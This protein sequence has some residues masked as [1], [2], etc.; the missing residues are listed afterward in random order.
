M[1]RKY[2][3]VSTLRVLLKG[4]S[5]RKHLAKWIP[6]NWS[7]G[8]FLYVCLF[9]WSLP[10]LLFGA[11]WHFMLGVD[12]KNLLI[13]SVKKLEWRSGDDVSGHQEKQW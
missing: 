3:S 9:S 5:P 7:V 13:P 2:K 12:L 11:L 4:S 6:L 8:E 10:A 1:L